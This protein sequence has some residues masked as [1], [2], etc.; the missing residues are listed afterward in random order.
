[1]DETES[2]VKRGE[3]FA[4]ITENLGEKGELFAKETERFA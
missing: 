4:N 2:F 1:M 3:A